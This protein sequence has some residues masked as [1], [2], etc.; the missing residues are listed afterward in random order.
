MKMVPGNKAAASATTHSFPTPDH[1]TAR[2]TIKSIMV[3]DASGIPSTKKSNSHKSEYS[4]NEDT[5]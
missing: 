1:P 5:I 4:T 3:P 2:L